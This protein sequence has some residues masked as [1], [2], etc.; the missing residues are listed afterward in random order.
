[1]TTQNSNAAAAQAAMNADF[2]AMTFVQPINANAQDG[3]AYSA[4]G[5]LN[6]NAP[7]IPGAFAA[8]I[9]VNNN[10]T[11]TLPSG[12]SGLLSPSAPHSAT[13]NI[14]VS[15][16]NEMVRVHPYVN[17]V[18]NELSGF[19]RRNINTPAQQTADVQ[20]M[21]YSAPTLN[22][23]ANTWKWTDRVILN[24]LHPQSPLGLLPQDSSGTRL[25]I[26]VQLAPAFAG[27]DP[28][29]NPVVTLAGGAISVTGSVT[30]T[31][32]YRGYESMAAP[33]TMALDLAG[34]PTLYV[35]KPDEINPLTAGSYAFKRLTQP[36]SIYRM[37]HVVIDGQQADKFVSSASNVVGYEM[38]SAENTSSAFFKYD[39][40]TGGIQNYYLRN[41]QLYGRD[42]DSGVF[43]QDFTSQ[44]TADSSLRE[45]QAYLNLTGSGYPAGRFGFQVNTVGSVCTPRVVSYVWAIN[46]APLLIQ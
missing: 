21:I 22:V 3:T 30:V 23:G 15:Y 26:Q 20:S 17:H 46:P 29:Q 41:R 37:V 38:D 9:L 12:T 43:V 13:A 34:L 33:A 6:F 44:N 7:I 4:G 8:E 27:S 45:G 39:S 2:M 28:L 32:L 18:A 14:I 42:F 11:V 16:A 31:V 1:M 24:N 5:V 10:L 40:T 35:I 19:N 36:Y 25:Q